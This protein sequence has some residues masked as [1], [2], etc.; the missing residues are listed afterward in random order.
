MKHYAELNSNG[1]CVS[2]KTVL[3]ELNDSNLVEIEQYDTSYMYK[4]Y[5]NGQWSVEQYI[6]DSNQIVLTE[7]EKVKER[8][9][10]MQQA[11]DDLILN[12]GV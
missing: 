12:G 4:K 6:P 9:Q 7:F 11:L 2:I 1:I 8:Q 10:L 3:S 5:E